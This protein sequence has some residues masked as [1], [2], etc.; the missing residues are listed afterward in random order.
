MDANIWYQL[1]EIIA[2]NKWKVYGTLIG[3]LSSIFILLIGFWR[4]LLILLL[5]VIGYII[6]SRWDQE[7]D[8]R[9]LLDR[10]LPPQFK[11]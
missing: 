5:T 7:G 10:L 2:N 6:G 4:T 3:F 1:R 11:D 8:F 9:K